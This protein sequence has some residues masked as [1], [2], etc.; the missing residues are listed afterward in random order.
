MEH[1]EL[2]SVR[3]NDLEGWNGRGGRL[4][5]EGVYVHIQLIQVVVQQKLR[6]C[7]KAI[8]FQLKNK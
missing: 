7:C 8:I 4:K 1:R 6:Q 5:R 3:C 2:S